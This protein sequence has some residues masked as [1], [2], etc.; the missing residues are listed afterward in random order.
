VKRVII[1]D[2]RPPMTGIVQCEIGNAAVSADLSAAA[3]RE[4]NRR[5]MSV[6]M[7]INPQGEADAPSSASSTIL[8]PA[9]STDGDSK[10]QDA[11]DVSL[12]HEDQGT[13]E[14]PTSESECSSPI[15]IT[16]SSSGSRKIVDDT[17][18]EREDQGTTDNKSSTSDSESSSLGFSSPSRSR[19]YCLSCTSWSR[20]RVLI[21][22]VG[23]F[24]AS[25]VLVIRLLLDTEP[26]AYIIH[27]LVV[28]VDMVLIHMFTNS[29][30]LSISGQITTFVFVL[31]F[32]FTKETV[33][34]L[35]E[36]TI[37]AALCSFHL[38]FLR[39]K[40]MDREEELEVGFESL[41]QQNV[42]L[43]RERG[44]SGEIFEAELGEIDEADEAELR[45][46][47]EAELGEIKES[48][49][50]SDTLKHQQ[51]TSHCAIGCGKHFFEHF[52]HGSA[53][54]M[55]TSFLGLII[56]ALLVYGGD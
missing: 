32:H 55:Y 20:E 34:E 29:R 49:S 52:L 6:L 16:P 56:D 7:H 33:F 48:S 22:L 50:D 42:S 39:N 28:F 18:L 11:E 3:Q 2:D 31:G 15:D 37:I 8:P 43:L 38:I 13:T 35:L 10:E 17:T 51:E 47:D 5:Y 21:A 26:T 27:S 54:V 23:C 19:K 9:C 44:N 12:E 36:T 45:D 53:G 46:I 25:V 30:W 24:S 40:H 41:R 1:T 14:K 4:Q